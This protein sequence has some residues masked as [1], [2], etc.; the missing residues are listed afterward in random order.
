MR[1]GNADGF[2]LMAVLWILVIVGAV[3][4]A[5]QADAG[6]ERR[7]VANARTGVRVRWGAR[8][9]LH[10]TL[11][12]LDSSVVRGLADPAGNAALLRPIG[13]ELD[14]V[15]IQAQ[16]IDARARVN[17]NLAD[18][19]RL[20]D[21]FAA[22][23]FDAAGAHRVAAAVMDWRDA[24]G[25][26]RPEGAEAADYAAR[27]MPLPRNAPFEAVDDLRHVLGMSP[28][29]FRRVAPHLTVVGDGRINVNSASM[30]ALAT[31]PGLDLA[32]A[33]VIA[34]RRD[35]WRLR[36]VFELTTALPRE[37]QNAIQADMARFT[38]M[39]AF[40]PRALEI[41]VDA[42]TAGSPVATH[43]W[44]HVELTG[45]TGWRVVRVVER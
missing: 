25:L 7:V 22:S 30:P 2:A 21:L 23:G 11:A 13:F 31:L 44:A 10:R 35:S 20:R 18:Q 28:E 27:G 15:A 38:D 17:L 5:F 9:G 39:V 16:A 3:G 4:I 40:G 1:T 14:G 32:S 36:N 26:R 37:T 29:R 6:A 41:T 8:A 34:S 43:L 42:T 33:R 12:A 45:G 24:D 19:D